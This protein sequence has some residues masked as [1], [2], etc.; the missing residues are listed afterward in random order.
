MPCGSFFLANVALVLMG[1]FG[2]LLASEAITIATEGRQ[3]R[4]AALGERVAVTYAVGED[5]LVTVSTDEGKTFAPAVRA[6]SIPRLCSGMRRGPQIALTAKSLV[7]AGIGGTAGDIMAWSSYDFGVTWSSPVTVNDQPKA[8]AE[9]LFSLAAGVS[10]TVWAVWLDVRQKTAKIEI[11]RSVDGAAA[12][13]ANRVFYAAPKGG[14]CECCQPQ[15]AADDASG[16]AVMWRNHIGE[17]RDLWLST[18]NN[19]GM[20]FNAPAKL[21]SGTWNL[22]ACPM[23]G[24]GVEIA[25]TEVHTIW[26]REN[27]LFTT[28]PSATKET[29]IGIGKNGTILIAGKQV[30]RAWQSNDRIFVA[31]DGAAPRDLGAGG[32]PQL[33]GGA[34]SATGEKQARDPV[35][36]VWESGREVKALRLDD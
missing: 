7:V 36:V 32:Y 29:S 15:I 5:I 20:S 21:G 6:G 31:I 9:G 25:G 22:N 13:M 4:V 35:I 12:W 23:D 8:A 33:A 34:S 26:R 24:G 30:Y 17:A 28:A 27:T 16:V 2:K 11:S 14:V 18:S 19:D 3:P 1:M 10:D